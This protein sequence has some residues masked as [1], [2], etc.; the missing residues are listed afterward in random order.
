MKLDI[1]FKGKIIIELKKKAVDKIKK[2]RT[3]FIM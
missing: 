3:S 2:D 1:G